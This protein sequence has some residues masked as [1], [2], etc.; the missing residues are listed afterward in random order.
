MSQQHPSRFGDSPAATLSE[1][2]TELTVIAAAAPELLH[3]IALVVRRI[4]AS[5]TA[6]SADQ[7]L[8]RL[9]VTGPSVH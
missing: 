3:A 8:A 4:R 9:A 1:I 7:D 2:H 6:C 5:S